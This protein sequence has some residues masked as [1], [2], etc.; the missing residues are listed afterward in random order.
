LVRKSISPEMSHSFWLVMLLAM[1][2]LVEKHP[3]ALAQISSFLLRKKEGFLMTAM[4]FPPLILSLQR[5]T[6]LHPV[7][8]CFISAEIS[9]V[10]GM[11]SM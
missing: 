10:I 7:R 6:A 8:A 1:G 3:N 5:A 9:W 4:G 2:W 11:E